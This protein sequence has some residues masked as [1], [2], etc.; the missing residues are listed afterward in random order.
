MR[1]KEFINEDVIITGWY[2]RSPVPY[3]ELKTLRDSQGR[4]MS[5]YVYLVKLTVAIGLI[6]LGVAFV[7]LS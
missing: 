1:A 4:L 2:R 6:I 7:L 3:I 5:C